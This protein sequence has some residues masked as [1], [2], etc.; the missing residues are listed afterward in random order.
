MRAILLISVL[1]VAILGIVH[2]T[3]AHT[4]EPAHCGFWGSIEA[5]LSCQ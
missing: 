4:G 5:G 1:I 3:H 2:E